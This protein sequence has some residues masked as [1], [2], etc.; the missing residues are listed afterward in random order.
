MP[1]VANEKETIMSKLTAAKAPSAAVVRR[2]IKRFRKIMAA[3]PA[4]S[5]CAPL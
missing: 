3:M 4:P 5:A 1:I 2:R